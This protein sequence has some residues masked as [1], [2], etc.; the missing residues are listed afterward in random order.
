MLNLKVIPA[1]ELIQG[2]SN[3]AGGGRGGRERETENSWKE[4]RNVNK[5]N[6][7]LYRG[8]KFKGKYNSNLLKFCV[9]I[10]RQGRNQNQ[11]KVKR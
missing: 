8:D 9:R 5:N 10:E 4:R 11:Q 6:V 3:C 2:K 7:I 1:K